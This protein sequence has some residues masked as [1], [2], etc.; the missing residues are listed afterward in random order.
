[1]EG[2]PLE[3]KRTPLQASGDAAATH[4][5]TRAAV[6]PQGREISGARASMSLRNSARQLPQITVK[7]RQIEYQKSADDSLFMRSC[8]GKANATPIASAPKKNS[9]IFAQ[10]RRRSAA[11]IGVHHDRHRY[12]RQF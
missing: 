2:K 9:G 6:D 7:T 11:A 10:F 4:S 1:V 8:Q 5:F 12:A 3:E